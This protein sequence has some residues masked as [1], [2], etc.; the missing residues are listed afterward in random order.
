M[1]KDTAFYNKA[2]GHYSADRYPAVA[3]SYTQFFFKRRLDIVMREL[4]YL[5][6]GKKGLTLLEIG[7]ADGVVLRAV[8]TVFHDSFSDVVGIDT[9]SDMIKRAAMLSFGTGIRFLMRGEYIEKEL[10]DVVIEVGVV[11]YADVDEE[12]EYAEKIL[13]D[14]GVYILSIAGKNSL[15]GYFGGG[16]GYKNFSPYHDYEDK[17]KKK[18][19]IE[20]VIPC[21]FFVP[22]LWKSPIVGRVIQPALEKIFSRIAPDLFHEKIYILK[23]K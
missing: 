22:L 20:Q 16:V 8:D 11:N 4:R 2:S 15:N 1:I 10:L 3:R 19:T 5:L 18:F 12:L 23:I 14:T 9:S 17:I 21:G 13:K 6:G 7:C